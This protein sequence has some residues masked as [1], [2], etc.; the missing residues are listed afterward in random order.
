[1]SSKSLPDDEEFNVSFVQAVEK[2][3]CLYDHTLKAYSNRS[4][5]DKAWNQVAGQYFSTG[6]KFVFFENTLLIIAF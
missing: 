2:Y 1:M 4:E 6:N 5:Q 3:P